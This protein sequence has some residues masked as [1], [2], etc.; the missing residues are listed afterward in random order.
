LTAPHAMRTVMSGTRISFTYLSRAQGS[1]R[2]IRLQR[3][4][5][6][7]FWPVDPVGNRVATF[8]RVLGANSS[9]VTGKDS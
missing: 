3:I 7:G 5:G 6:R 8:H 4:T 1:A 9:P 2:K